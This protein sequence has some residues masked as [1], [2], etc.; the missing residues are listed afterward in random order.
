MEVPLE[1]TFAVP[2]KEPEL[3]RFAPIIIWIQ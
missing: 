1:I 3:L 2:L